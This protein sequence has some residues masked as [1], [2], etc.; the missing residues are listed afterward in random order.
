LA[1]AGSP[2]PI[3][4]YSTVQSPPEFLRVVIHAAG[5]RLMIGNDCRPVPDSGEPMALEQVVKSAFANLA[6]AVANEYDVPLSSD[7]LALLERAIADAVG[8]A[9]QDEAA[10]WSA[11]VK[12]GCF[13]GEVLRESNGGHWMV[14]DSGSL[15]FALSTR[16]RGEQATVNPLGKVIKLFA[17]GD[18]DSLVELVNIIRSHP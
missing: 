14:V 8:I 11:V 6:Q 15:P 12:L 16:F 17:N 7:G 5:G 3:V 18:G 13:G 2:E 4:F 9:E 10:Y 1:K